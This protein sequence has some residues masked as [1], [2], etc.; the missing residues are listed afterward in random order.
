M[1]NQDLIYRWLDADQDTEDACRIEL[2]QALLDDPDLLDRF[3]DEVDLDVSLRSSSVGK[4][5]A[6][7]HRLPSG[8]SATLVKQARRS[9]RRQARRSNRSRHSKFPAFV[10]AA[11]LMAAILIVTLLMLQ[12]SNVPMSEDL[13]LVK[14]SQNDLKV[15]EDQTQVATSP[16][17][18]A[19]VQASSESVFTPPFDE[20][21]PQIW[22]LTEGRLRVSVDPN[23]ASMPLSIQ[24]PVAVASVQGTQFT[25]DHS[26]DETTLHVHEGLVHFSQSPG[27]PSYLIGGGGTAKSDRVLF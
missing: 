21:V 20:H 18:W 7:S 25:V 3:I 2:E 6:A 17:S 14:N 5:K 16:V 24:T 26:D 22:T 23:R 12:R 27:G 1:K 8:E 4:R 19:V 9:G 13:G 15:E 10:S 11:G